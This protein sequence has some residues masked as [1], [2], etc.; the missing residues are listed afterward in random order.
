LRKGFI[1]SGVVISV[2]LRLASVHPGAASSGDEVQ[3]DD[4]IFVLHDALLTTANQRA[5]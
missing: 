4:V 5:T 2:D 1:C 3:H